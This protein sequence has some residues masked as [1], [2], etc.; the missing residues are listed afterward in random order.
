MAMITRQKEVETKEKS[1]REEQKFG[2]HTITPEF[3]FDCASQCLV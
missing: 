3:E 1:Q 2:R